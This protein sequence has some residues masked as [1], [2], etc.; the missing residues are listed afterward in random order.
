M[1]ANDKTVYFVLGDLDAPTLS[2]APQSEEAKKTLLQAF[3]SLNKDFL[4]ESKRNLTDELIKTYSH[5]YLQQLATEIN[6]GMAANPQLAKERARINDFGQVASKWREMALASGHPDATAVVFHCNAIIDQREQALQL[7]QQAG[8]DANTTLRAMKMLGAAAGNI[9][10]ALEVCEAL[11]AGATEPD[12]FMEKAFGI[13]LGSLAGTLM[14]GAA[15]GIATVLAAPIG[16]IVAVG[17]LVL[18]AAYAAEKIGEFIWDEFISDNFWAFLESRGWRDNVENLVSQ[19]GEWVGVITPGEPAPPYRTEQVAGGE[20]VASNEKENVVIGNDGRNEIVM[21]HGRTVAYGEGGDDIYRVH[22]TAH[23]NQVISDVEGNNEIIFGIE[24]L[25]DLEF[26]AIGQGVFESS[27]GNYKAVI[28]DDGT[29]ESSLVI[30]SRNYDATVTILDWSNGNFGLNLLGE[31]EQP[32]ASS[33][34]HPGSESADYINPTLTTPD[35]SYINADGGFGRD[36][37]TGTLGDD[38][39]TGGTGSDIINGNDGK[40]RIIGGYDNDMITGFGDESIVEGGEGEDVIVASHSFSW[41]I[42]PNGDIRLDADGIWRDLAPYFNWTSTDGFM[43]LDGGQLA[44]GH[45]FDV[46]GTFDHSGA[47]SITG[48]TYRF[49]STTGETY[50][51]QYY[52]AAEPNGIS[53][54]GGTISYRATTAQF[55]KGVSLYGGTGDDSIIGSAA[56]DFIDGGHDDDL[57]AGDRGND[58]IVGGFGDDR[59]AGGEGNDVIDGGDNS[60]IVHGEEGNDTIHGGGGNDFLWGDRYNEDNAAAGGNDL[61][62]GGA[63]NDQLIGGGG[64][65]YLSGGDEIDMVI[66]GEGNDLIFGGQGADELQG[67]AGNDGLHGDA[68]DDKLWGQDGGDYLSGGNGTDQLVGG[69]GNDSLDG[70]ADND[71]LFGQAGDDKLYGG[72]GDDGLQGDDGADTINGGD[73]NDQ[74]FGNAGQDFLRGDNGEDFLAGGTENDQLSG[75]A[76]VDTL[77]GEDGDDVLDGGTENDNLYAGNGND[78]AYGG[79]GNDLIY[80]HAGNDLLLGG[81]GDDY[82][83]GDE[84]NDQLLGGAGNDTL[85]GGLGAD[86]LI[87]DAG[88]DTLSGGDGDDVFVFARGFGQDHIVDLTLKASGSNAIRF[89]DTIVASDITYA[90]SGLDL[91]ISISGGSDKLTVHGFLGSLS[92]QIIFSDNSVATVETVLAVLGASVMTGT[93]G[94]DLLYGTAGSDTLSGLGGDDVIYGLAGNDQIFGGDGNDVIY[95]ALG[96]N[97][98]EGGQGNDV[99]YI[100]RGAGT[101]TIQGLASTTSGSDIIRLVGLLPSDMIG[102]QVSGS[103]LLIILSYSNSANIINLPGFLSTSNGT[104]VL[105]FEDGARYTANDF[106]NPSSTWTGTAGN[107]RYIAS[108]GSNTLTALAGN[109]YVS[110]LGGNDSIFGNDG[111]DKLYGDDGNDG[112]DGGDGNDLLAGGKNDDTLIG[113]A[114]D[115]TLDGGVGND[116]LRGGAGNNIYIFNRGHGSDT[117]QY[118]SP[119]SPQ[120][121]LLQLGSG[122]LASEIELTRVNDSLVIKI[123]G[124]SDKITNNSFFASEIDFKIRFADGSIWAT[125]NMKSMV[126]QATDGD[127]TIIGYSTD[128]V[129]DA[130][131]GNDQIQGRAGNDVLHGGVGNDILQ[132]GLGSDVYRFDVGWGIDVVRNYDQWVGDNTAERSDIDVIEFGAG[133]DPSDLSVGFRPYSPEL[134]SGHLEL[135]NNVTGD[136]IVVLSQFVDRGWSMSIEEVRFADGTIWDYAAICSMLPPSVITGTAAGWEQLVGTYFDDIISGMGG[137]GD[138]IRAGAGND[139]LSLGVGSWASLDG[140]T[141]SDTYLLDAYS[142]QVSISTGGDG[143]LDII[144]FSEN[145]SASDIRVTSGE[146]GT[147]GDLVLRNMVTGSS[148]SMSQHYTFGEQIEVHFAQDGTVWNEDT[149]RQLFQIPFEIYGTAGNDYLNGLSESPSVLYGFDGDDYLAGSRGGGDIFGGNGNDQLSGGEGD[150]LL[151]GGQGND[152]V[153]GWFGDDTYVFERSF[154]NDYVSDTGEYFS[155]DYDV[156]EFSSHTASE[157]SILRSGNDLFLLDKVTGDLI[158]INGQFAH[159]EDAQID[160]IRFA[161]DTIVDAAT[162]WGLESTFVVGNNDGEVLDGTA[163]NNYIAAYG[164]NDVIRGNEGNDTINGG[165]GN[166]ILDGG[167]GMDALNGGTGDDSYL[168]DNAGDVV[169]EL[170]GE[171]SDSVTALIAY[172]LSATIENLTLSGTAAI[173]GIGNDGANVLIGNGANNTLNG[174]D[175]NDVLDGQGGTDTLI[176][177]LG[178]DTYTVDAASDLVQEAINAGIDTVRSSL[179][180]TLGNNLENLVLT[181]ADDIAGTGNALHNLL[182]GNDGINTLFGMNGNDTLQGMAGADTLTG[183]TGNDTYVMARTYG[184]DTVVENDATTGNMDVIRFLSGVAYDQLWFTRPKGSKSLEVSIIGTADKLVIQNWYTGGQYQAEQFRTDDGSQVL[185]AADVQNLVDAMAN[186][187]PPAQGQTTLTASQ[188]AELDPV[189]ATAWRSQATGMQVMSTN[190]PALSTGGDSTRG[191]D[192]H[193][194]RFTLGDVRYSRQLHRAERWDGG[195]GRGDQRRALVRE[196]GKGMFGG[197]ERVARS[198]NVSGGISELNMLVAAMASFQVSEGSVT[199]PVH[200]QSHQLLFSTPMV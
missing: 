64:D 133:I 99:Y 23:G 108:N 32:P 34:T 49:W 161:D 149:I 44:L 150:D 8:V 155:Y 62:E 69:E 112:V 24:N 124:A 106:R 140:G 100:G 79:A 33:I 139:T 38:V 52:S 172:T 54:G 67:G 76:G 88:N 165:A 142:G 105:E 17:A 102:F 14:L 80:G 82:V 91:V 48:W 199:T 77:Y 180:W 40:D 128:D 179:G 152:Q 134:G 116:T 5:V 173:D 104:H 72:A 57:L 159:A 192:D 129:L 176:G 157:I 27:G 195:G 59:I 191:K 56:G 61:M 94:D 138:Y 153:V 120:Q 89:A 97:T 151:S 182:T 20:V 55:E 137:D 160:E 141:G 81:D 84:G 37:I 74:L 73:G 193:H 16:T 118:D 181:G 117:I 12:V 58:V 71:T 127:Q 169:A 42:Y 11:Q 178:N 39:L 28:V 65:D 184:V 164:G 1:I 135:R 188:R 156:V 78:S 95:D 29:G 114:G 183:D 187:T 123:N 125:E 30:S 163:D 92:N 53:T 126:L 147:Y 9:M 7:L 101:N 110:G 4:E 113:G 68:G 189:F 200:E 130:G 15:G 2:T 115:D 98:L 185:Y 136:V 96:T 148:V 51:L 22:T 107:D 3:V 36:F 166:D 35:L 6:E 167:V 21:L 174:M 131:A 175:G 111:D 119:G 41:P 50:S 143:A 19:V 121:H 197:E 109:D 10:L 103:D 13:A 26:H 146:F 132:G 194:N 83:G 122:I 85:V 25:A 171:G 162:L 60:D 170:A 75:G 63:G 154:G 198:S 45:M 93:S 31:P 46:F 70:G 87:G 145:V 90:A 158:T 144:K 168:V 43:L 177:G 66:G 86:I 190:T 47:S 186:M 18:V 196:S